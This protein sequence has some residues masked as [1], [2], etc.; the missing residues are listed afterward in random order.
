LH[1]PLFLVS[2]RAKETTLLP[3]VHYNMNAIEIIKN[4]LVESYNLIEELSARLAEIQNNK[5]Q[6]PWNKK[7]QPSQAVKNLVKQMTPKTSNDSINHWITLRID[8][9]KAINQVI[10]WKNGMVTTFG[11][12]PNTENPLAVFTNRQ[13]AILR[14]R[15]AGWKVPSTFQM[16]GHHKMIVATRL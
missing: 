7:Q 2:S 1:P 15:K 9:V 10:L 4:S 6:L 5:P 16:G 11:E 8:N 12:D 13:T 14:L 3:L